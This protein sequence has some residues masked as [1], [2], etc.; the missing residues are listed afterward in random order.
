MSVCKDL[1]GKKFGYLTVVERVQNAKNGKARW[2][3]MCDCGNETIVTS[4]DIMTGHTSSCGCKRYESHNCVHGMN[5]TDIHT[6]WVQMRQRCYNKNY[7]SYAHYGAKG[8]SVCEEWK[9]DFIEFMNWSYSNGYKEGLSL[10]RIDNGKGYSPDN[11]RW[12]KWEDQSGNRTNNIKVTFN[13]KTQ[14]LRKWCTELGKDYL[15]IRQRIIRDG[16]TFEEAI[17]IPKMESRSHK[18]TE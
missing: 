14:N 16:M 12:V 2:K 9:T 8:I 10:D 18:R 11:C 15:F 3:C 5:K 17:S 13:G 7:V 4:T 6:K 1:T